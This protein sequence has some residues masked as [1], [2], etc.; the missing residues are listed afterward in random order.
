MGRYDSVEGGVAGGPDGQ[1]FIENFNGCR[2]VAAREEVR[3][4][5][6]VGVGGLVVHAFAHQAIGESE[7]NFGVVRVE[8]G[9]ALEGFEH[10]ARPTGARVGL[11]DDEVLRARFDQQALLETVERLIGR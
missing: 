3:A 6:C 1:D 11:S 2:M 10:L 4:G 5:L 9:N 7:A 8:V